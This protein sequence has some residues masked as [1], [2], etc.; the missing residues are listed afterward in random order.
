MKKWIVVLIIV[1]FLGGIWYLARTYGRFTPDWMKPTFGEVTRGDIRVPV[2]ASGLIEPEERIDV[3][4]EASG[5]VMVVKFEEGD[6]VRSGDILVELDPNDERRNLRI[7]QANLATAEAA[8]AQA[9]VAVQQARVS[10]E[11]S[12]AQIAELDARLRSA[13]SDLEETRRLHKD[14]HVS[15]RELITVEASYDALKA[16]RR[17]AEQSLAGAK[18]RVT[19]SQQL[20]KTNQANLEV[21]QQRVED[22][23]ERLAE[24]TVRAPEDALVTRVNV[25][26]GMIIQSGTATFTGGTSLL[27]LADISELKV[28]ARVNEADYGRVLE[29][30]PKSALPQMAA[31]AQAETQAAEDLTKRTGEVTLSVDAF[32]DLQFK[33]VI[34]RVEPQGRLNPGSSVIQFDVHI[35]VTD[36]RR[37]LLP[38]GAQAQVEFTVDS[39][40]DVLRVPAEAVKSF[41]DKRGV[42]VETPP[43]PGTEEQYGRRFVAL[44]LGITDGTYT[45]VVR[46]IGDDELEEGQNV[47]IKLP[48]RPQR[49]RD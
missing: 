40:E 15:D 6:F 28:V 11:T 9:E 42:W 47:Y 3:K 5:T 41:G 24:T 48:S 33:G 46:A 2:A 20:V 30:S 12:E 19:D 8:V 49:D 32:P 1:G 34:E 44:T 22:A 25:A 29:I 17:V 18:L 39:A 38:L 7:A 45:E 23:E 36:E 21:A 13:A 10:V 4:S 31:L 16:Q 14:G 35:R 37:H 43:E 27:E 26:S